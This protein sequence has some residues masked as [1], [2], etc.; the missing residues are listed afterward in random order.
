MLPKYDRYR[1]MAISAL[2]VL[3]VDLVIVLFD[4]ARFNTN[5]D[6]GI[7]YRIMGEW[8]VSEPTAFTMFTHIDISRVLVSLYE[9]MP[10]LPWYGLYL[11]LP[12]SIFHYLIFYYGLRNHGNRALLYMP[13]YFFSGGYYVFLELQFT[14]AAS[15][16]TVSG[17]VLLVQQIRK[18]RWVWPTWLGILF[19]AI[20]LMVRFK[21]AA[22]ILMCFL[23]LIAFFSLNYR[24]QRRIQ[25]GA[26]LFLALLL[27]TVIMQY[28]QLSA[29]QAHPEWKGTIEFNRVRSDL[30][31]FKAF[32]SLSEAD[33]V[34][35]LSEVG[36]SMNDY[37]M[38]MN[39]YFWNTAKYSMEALETISEAAPIQRKAF[40]MSTIKKSLQ[41]FF[42]PFSFAVLA[43]AI[44]LFFESRRMRREQWLL[45]YGVGLIALLYFISALVL[46][47]IP[48]RVSF[49]LFLAFFGSSLV[50]LR[51]GPRKR[52]KTFFWIPLSI[53]LIIAVANVFEAARKYRVS[54]EER[55]SI[56][57]LNSF[58][59]QDSNSIAL[60]RGS[61]F[62][63][64]GVTPFMKKENKPRGTVLVMGSLQQ[65]SPIK[66]HAKEIGVE[67]LAVSILSKPVYISV[68]KEFFEEDTAMLS[69]A[70]E[71]W[72]NLLPEWHTE[73]ESG[74]LVFI[75][76]GV[77]EVTENEAKER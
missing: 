21:Q 66:K 19:I 2:S 29:Y 34:Q 73:F 51:P 56:I 46:K 54:R 6:I 57:E 52:M 23:P 60:I 11:L 62:P 42:N 76:G 7:I 8:M 16:W 35:I 39:M 45:V 65:T 37:L 14:I 4:L 12:I 53:V 47:P 32:E 44:W 24:K 74:R 17:L 28:R 15:A 71:E 61:R 10:G 70:F 43:M 68:K 41:R 18:D 20:G 31:D 13:V 63:W 55:K 33:Q 25:R 64:K 3:V 26:I 36:W 1:A 58:L 72:A 9:L 22:V 67:R 27:S 59:E 48:E 69:T 30:H 50:F 49:G 5:D 75:R 40:G 77:S 38:F